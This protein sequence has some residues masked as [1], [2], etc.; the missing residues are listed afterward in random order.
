MTWRHAFWAAVLLCAGVTACGEQ[1]KVTRDEPDETA[2]ASSTATGGTTS[3]GTGGTTHHGTGG[4]KLSTGGSEDEP[5]G[6]VAGAAGSTEVKDPCA[7]ESCPEDQ[8]CEASGSESACVPN[9]CQTLVC[10]DNEE[11]ETTAS[12]AR[13]VS[14]A[15]E[16]D[17]DCPPER[18]CDTET[19]LCKDD[20]CTP[21]VRACNA[22][23]LEECAANGGGYEALA[24]C[25]AP[26][27][28]Q[29]VCVDLGA[30]SAGCSCEDDWD[31]PDYQACESGICRG[32]TKPATCRL[33][34][35]DITEVL[36][37]L[38]IQWGGT[39]PSDVE[40]KL[41]IVDGVDMSSSPPSP[42]PDSGQ[43]VHTPLV[44]NLDDDNGD[45]VIDERDFPE[46]VFM[47]FVTSDDATC[48]GMLRAI[49]GGG[50]DANGVSKKGRDY[51][52]VCSP[53]KRWLEG[54]YLDGANN[55]LAQAPDCGETEP[56]LDPTSTMAIGDLDYDGVPEIVA[57]VENSDDTRTDFSK[58]E[59]ALAVYSNQGRRIF[60]YPED[61]TQFLTYDNRSDFNNPSVTLA[62][63]VVAAN[64]A[65]DLVEIVVGSDLFLLEK[66]AGV[67]RVQKRFTGGD[68]RG[69]NSQGPIS[70]VADVVPDRPGQE[71]VAG[72]TV[73]GVPSDL[74]GDQLQVLAADGDR[75]GFCAIADVWGADPATAPGPDNPP[76]G[77]PEIVLI[78]DGSLYIYSLSQANGAYSMVQIPGGT[79]RVPGGNGGG[80]PNVDDF[81]GDGFAE[82][83]TAG[84]TGYE[85]FDLQDPVP[86]YCPEW[87]DFTDDQ[88]TSPRV[89][90]ATDCSECAAGT[91]CNS[92]LDNRRCICLH[93]GWSRP[94]IDAS[95]M[96]TGS[97]V[98]DFNGDGA[99]EVI[100]NDECRFRIYSGL[101]GSELMV[102]WSESRTRT[103][104]PI[105]ADIDNDGNAEIVFAAS[106]ESEFC[107]EA[108]APDFGNG[109]QV[110]GDL[111]D[112][113]VSA[114][115]VWN[116]HAYHVTNVTES[117]AIPRVEPASWL[118]L[119]NRYYNTYRSQPRSYGVAPDLIV[120]AIQV[121]SPDAACGKLS[122]QLLIS[123]EVRNQGDLRVGPGVVVTFEGV[124]G[125]DPAVPLLDETGNPLV[126]VITSSLDPGDSLVFQVSYAASNNAAEVLPDRL[127]VTVDPSG[128][129]NQ[130][131]AERECDDL[132]NSLQKEVEPGEALPDLA[133]E[134]GT[135]DPDCPS[136]VVRGTVSNVG[137][138]AA[139]NILVRIYAG[140]PEAGGKRL[141]DVTIPGP[142]QPGAS[143]DFEVV[144]T[145]FPANQHIRVWAIAD[146]EDVIE[147][148]NNAN[149]KDGPSEDLFCR[150]DS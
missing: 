46:I 1:A 37:S 107:E 71:I 146:P 115:R 105:V 79:R 94:T 82:I 95:S 68:V 81:D 42:W 132:N 91:I 50:V 4:A 54:Q 103:E 29:S 110:W 78:S 22:D 25:A 149:N 48:N 6:D 122:S 118:P 7:S 14:V 45:G 97:S 114:R 136:P 17:V 86:E 27:A 134:L 125:T 63:V 70:C 76:D 38:E 144:L 12:G 121:S 28:Y 19:G 67:L 21:G 73:Y 128:P 23:T 35:L 47:T 65:E 74:S 145:N 116:Q 84:E 26:T 39:S 87:P 24:L 133:L 53:N 98:F 96:V 40:A 2:G 141:A 104:Y 106:N 10:A 13:C 34:A 147:E 142:L 51:F 31:C 85:M 102:R 20:T 60:R 59:G 135:P 16:G 119:G 36:P 52:A 92:S 64:P 83:G 90:P 93:N 61:E 123:V 113:W 129:D 99:A 100:Y 124:W 117:L 18:W 55:P 43:F 33:P 108:D 130:F 56:D 62:N 80:P 30:G 9:E 143:E 66:A 58:R 112:R 8:H 57:L 72:A 137:A 44:A 15:C 126:H 3:T 5:G 150:Q 101:D 148:C 140:D 75:D 11:C 88:S 41:R 49:H 120:G 127:L 139:S 109:V 131:G 32:D 111:D 138:L 77:V 69:I 89:P